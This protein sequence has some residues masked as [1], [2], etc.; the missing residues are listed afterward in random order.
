MKTIKFFTLGCKV[1]QYETQCIREQ[2]LRKGFC[3]VDSNNPTDIYVINTCTVTHTADHKSRHLIRQAVRENPE[4]CV[5]VTGCFAQTNRDDI[6]KIAGVNFIIGNEDKSRLIELV[7]REESREQKS[8]F[9]ISDFSTHSRAFVKIQD[10]CSNSCSYCKVP[11]VRGRSKSRDILEIK[12]E[13]LRLKD[14]GFKEIVLCGICL[15]SYGKDFIFPMELG[16]VIEEIERI[17]G[18]KRIRLS[19]LEARDVNQHLVERLKDSAKLC[20]HLHIPFQSGDD[21]ILKAMNRNYCV[22]D[23]RRIIVNIRKAV[24]H[25]NITT[26]IMVGF[27]GESEE[28]FQNTIK[29]LKDIAPSRIHIF[30]FSPREGTSAYNLGNRCLASLITER[31]KV[32]EEL[33][34]ELSFSYRKQF[35]NKEVEVLFEKNRDGDTGYLKGYSDTYIKVLSHFQDKEYLINQISFVKINRV[36]RYYTFGQIVAPALKVALP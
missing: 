23:Y 31:K 11:F 25:I 10:G 15:G 3:E 22:D 12:D 34:V 20:P 13:A 27:P 17:D 18:I 32:L 5:I 36:E 14:N 8:Q 30:P 6:A 2:F 29:F 9:G 7:M 28:H 4:G 16:D 35:L 21:Q 26:D 24:P 19:S 1:N 33:A